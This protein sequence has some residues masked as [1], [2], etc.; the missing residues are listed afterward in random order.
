MPFVGRLRI[1]TPFENQTGMIVVWPSLSVVEIC[2]FAVNP[3]MVVVTIAN[4]GVGGATIGVVALALVGAGDDVH[5]GLLL[6]QCWPLGE[7]TQ[8]GGIAK[9]AGA[10]KSNVE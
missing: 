10:S 2:E 7:S 8:H 1:P 6:V 4:T 9:A 5:I 3:G